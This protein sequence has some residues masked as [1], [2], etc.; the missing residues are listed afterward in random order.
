MIIK[1]VIFFQNAW[2][3]GNSLSLSLIFPVISGMPE[4]L[5]ENKNL[6][7]IPSSYNNSSDFVALVYKD[8]VCTKH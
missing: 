1:A 4:I 6:D 3:L 5:L 2:L 7:G 8:Q